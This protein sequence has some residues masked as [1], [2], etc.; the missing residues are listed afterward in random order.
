MARYWDRLRGGSGEDR[1]VAMTLRARLYRTQFAIANA[2]KKYGV[3]LLATGVDEALDSIEALLEELVC[4][5]ERVEKTEDS[6][7]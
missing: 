6:K 2:R 4:R 5:V 1:R 3:M 7:R